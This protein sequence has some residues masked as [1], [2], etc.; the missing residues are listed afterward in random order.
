MLVGA[1]DSVRMR[2]NQLET[3][4][5]LANSEFSLGGKRGC[6]YEQIRNF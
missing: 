1:D 6:P 5:F 2:K 4:K 3:C